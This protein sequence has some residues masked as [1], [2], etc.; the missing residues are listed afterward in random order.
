MSMNPVKNEVT[1]TLPD[2]LTDLSTVRARG[3]RWMLT[4]GAFGTMHLNPG[5]YDKLEREALNT[6]CSHQIAIDVARTHPDIFDQQCVRT[7]VYTCLRK[8]R[9]SVES[10]LGELSTLLRTLQHYIPDPGYT[11][12]FNFMAFFA[13]LFLPR[14]H[15][16]WLMVHYLTCM[17]PLNYFE[18]A[19]CQ[20]LVIDI[21]VAKANV[22]RLVPMYVNA[23]DFYPISTHTPHTTHFSL[24][25]DVYFLSSASPYNPLIYRL[26]SSVG[27]EGSDLLLSALAPKLFISLGLPLLPLGPLLMLWDMY[28]AAPLDDTVDVGVEVANTCPVLGG[29]CFRGDCE[30][31]VCDGMS[32]GDDSSFGKEACEEKSRGGQSADCDG[33][34]PRKLPKR[35]VSHRSYGRTQTLIDPS[36]SERVGR[37]RRLLRRWLAVHA[38]RKNW[39]MP[40]IP[41]G[42]FLWILFPD[43]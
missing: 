23:L 11:Q 40:C 36:G 5:L 16:F 22:D 24:S 10:I 39:Q 8:Q 12:G 35:T 26:N 41:A 33:K 28:W 18:S 43:P 3:L 38:D 21:K 6:P 25:I 13:L 17:K 37:T 42:N 34:T 1:F 9:K 30:G 14:A 27:A 29:A 2:Y 19:R 32:S 4:S 31:G 15:V 20:G 7:F